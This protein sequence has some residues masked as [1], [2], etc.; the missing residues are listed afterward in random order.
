MANQ[1]ENLNRSFVDGDLT[2][3][4]HDS[5]TLA[6]G[7][8]VA[9]GAGSHDNVAAGAGGIAAHG[10]VTQADHGG[11][12][13]DGSGVGGPI[14]T[15]SFNSVVAGGGVDHTNAGQGNIGVNAD[16]S[17]GG[18]ASTPRTTPTPWWTTAAA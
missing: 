3:V 11:V 4:S 1:Q 7:H 17:V 12:A 10:N 2:N 18:L 5:T 13:L 6:T 14:A 8:G 15:N 16:G 9:F